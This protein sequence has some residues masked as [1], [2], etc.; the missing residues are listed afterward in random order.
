MR[1]AL[2]IHHLLDPHSGA[3]G[4]VLALADGYRRRGHEVELFSHSDLPARM[5]PR[6]REMA[7]PVFVAS[8]LRRAM[9]DRC[10]DVIDASTADAWLWGIA[11]RRRRE[12]PALVTS[13]NGL[14]HAAHARRLKEAELGNIELSWKYPLYFGGF[15]LREVE[16][17]LR[18]AD[19]ALFL[20]RHDRAYAI[21][22]LGVAPSR[23]H[24]VRN[25]V[26]DDL[27]GLRRPQADPAG[28]RIA[29]I[30][31]Y[32]PGKGIRY[33]ARAL[34]RILERRDDVS[35]R[36]LGTGCEPERVL[37]DF[38]RAV[39]TRIEVVSH[40]ERKRL[41]ELV[42]DCQVKLF[43]TLSEGWGNVALEAMACGL[44]PVTTAVPGPM[45]FVRD[46][47]NGLIVPPADVDALTSAVERLLDEPPLLARLREAAWRT[48]QDYGWQSVADQ[49][50]A[51]YAGVLGE[52]PAG[53]A[54]AARPV[55]AVEMHG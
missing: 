4:G 15:R 41:P 42:A 22:R 38:D 11:T 20:N 27:L 13:S 26:P 49:R 47:K 48:A 37:A 14:E 23:A 3:A 36:F 34:G 19:A 40:F 50:L 18:L 46:G 35:V 32:I 29:Q 17:S 54:G 8:H 51:I 28:F 33:G 44:A 6:A 10:L 24:L 43:P 16:A 12:R 31:S 55:G 52:R 25:G 1:I 7:F 39:H 53:R 45:M 30:G 9:K 21:Q 5:S 2:V